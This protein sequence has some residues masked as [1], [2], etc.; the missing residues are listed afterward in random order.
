MNR[1]KV[2]QFR[3]ETGGSTGAPRVYWH[4][5]EEIFREIRYLAGIFASR[6][7]V[8]AMVPKRHIYGYLWTVLLPAE[9]RVEVREYGE[10]RGGD[11]VVGHPGTWKNLGEVPEDVWA[12]NSGGPVKMEE[13]RALRE[14]GLARWFDVYGSTETAGLAIREDEEG[15]Y[16]LFPW[17]KDYLAG[18]EAPDRVEWFSPRRMVLRG[19]KDEAVQV[20]GV[21]VWPRRVEEILERCEGVERVE[22]KLGEDGWLEAFWVG[23][24]DEGVLKQWA[25]ANLR[26]PDRP[27]RFERGGKFVTRPGS[28]YRRRPVGNL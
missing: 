4:G 14:R 13:V 19:R 22:V 10:L 20:K 6:R 23:D 9:L 8:V 15:P 28:G 11:L 3:F 24:A 18:V 16:E 12:V 1:P 26:R 25:E 2:L 5:R 7:R 27:V 17:W 21:N